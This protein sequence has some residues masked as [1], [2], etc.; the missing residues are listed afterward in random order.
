MLPLLPQ[1]W[2]LPL[3]SLLIMIGGMQR[4]T[5]L[6]AMLQVLEKIQLL[7]DL[8]LSPGVNDALCALGGS[9]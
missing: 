6:E 1:C 5:D 8:N 2:L 4:A 7:L 3:P 9:V